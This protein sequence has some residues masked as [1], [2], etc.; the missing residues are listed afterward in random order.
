M[1]IY[2]ESRKVSLGAGVSESTVWKYTVPEHFTVE[3]MEVGFL[4]P[5]DGH[6]D[7]YIDEVKIDNLDGKAFP[8]M[9]YRAVVNRKMVKG[10]FWEF[11]A[12][13]VLAG[14]FA[15]MMVF[16]KSKI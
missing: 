4:I 2:N 16:D 7:G 15:V 9:Q 5:D 14:D 12:T 10:Q 13:S 3:V 8:D 11:K 6:I 1:V